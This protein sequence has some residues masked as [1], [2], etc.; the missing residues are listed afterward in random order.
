MTIGHDQFKDEIE[1]LPKTPSFS[2]LYIKFGYTPTNYPNQDIFNT[3]Q[4]KLFHR[5]IVSIE[6][7][8]P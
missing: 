7:Q 3:L 2:F 6:N 8:K 4:L 1:V 5:D